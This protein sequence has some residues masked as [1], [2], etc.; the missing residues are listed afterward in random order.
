LSC[1]DPPLGLLSLVFM[2]KA[3]AFLHAL[4]QLRFIVDHPF[5]ELTVFCIR[6]CHIGHR[7]SREINGKNSGRIMSLFLINA[8]LIV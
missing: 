1:I 6:C 3:K 2:G 4:A 5:F 7:K 8:G